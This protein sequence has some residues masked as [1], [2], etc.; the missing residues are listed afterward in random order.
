MTDTPLRSPAE[1]FEDHLRCRR[2]GAVEEDLARN[3]AADVVFLTARGLFHGHAGV[4]PNRVPGQ[5]PELLSEPRE[6]R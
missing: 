4:G 3:Y 2:E 1:V 5:H 6:L